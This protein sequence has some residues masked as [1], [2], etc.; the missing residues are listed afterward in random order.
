MIVKMKHL[1]DNILVLC[2]FKQQIRYENKNICYIY[3]TTYFMKRFCFIIILIAI[4]S[5]SNSQTVSI[6]KS[7]TTTAAPAKKTLP[8]ILFGGIS[9]KG[10]AEQGQGYPSTLTITDDGEI[11]SFIVS[12]NLGGSLKEFTMKGDHISPEAQ[13]CMYAVRSGRKIFI[14]DIKYKIKGESLVRKSNDIVISVK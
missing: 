1:F 4:T 7:S 11:I 8:K 2:D 9:E 5:K 13:Q 12:M 6:P 10:E 3:I 14:Q